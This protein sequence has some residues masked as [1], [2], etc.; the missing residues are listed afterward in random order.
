M[1]ERFARIDSNLV[2]EE[3]KK[4]E[5]RSERLHPELNKII[6]EPELPQKLRALFA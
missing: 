4:A 5:K 3:L 6:R 2:V 1:E